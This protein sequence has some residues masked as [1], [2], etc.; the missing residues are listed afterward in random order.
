MNCQYCVHRDKIIRYG[1]D[2][3]DN[4]IYCCTVS[5]DKFTD[6]IHGPTYD[7]GHYYNEVQYNRDQVNE[8]YNA[9][10]KKADEEFA[11]YL[12]LKALDEEE[13]EKNNRQE[14]VYQSSEAT[15]D[16][17]DDFLF[18]LPF[19]A[20]VF[21]AYNWG[22]TA[23]KAY[24]I[25]LIVLTI[26]ICNGIVSISESSLLYKLFNLLKNIITIG[27]GLGVL[28]LFVSSILV[29]TSV[30]NVIISVLFVIYVIF[31]AMST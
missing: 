26:L 21:I 9:L 7:C 5:G 6:G 4:P 10:Y 13:A 18:L 14:P 23:V 28:F 22:V 27:I 17:I 19:A 12:L 8:Q 2:Y 1:T 30:L 11:T 25:F 15:S 31:K 29:S 20:L 16:P 3:N 24:G